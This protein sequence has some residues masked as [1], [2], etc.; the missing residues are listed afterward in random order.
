MI[1]KFTAYGWFYYCWN[2]SFILRCDPNSDEISFC[3]GLPGIDEEVPEDIR[4]L[5]INF[6]LDPLFEIERKRFYVD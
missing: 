1:L 5:F 4:K 3:T 6:I 2:E